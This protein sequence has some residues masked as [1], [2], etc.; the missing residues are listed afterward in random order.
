MHLVKENK[1][2][3]HESRKIS[4]TMLAKEPSQNYCQRPVINN[5]CCLEVIA[6][7]IRLEDISLHSAKN[8]I[9]ISMVS[10]KLQTKF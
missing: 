1:S 2:E 6:S 8:S 3:I 9:V 10:M 4:C 5:P 7:V